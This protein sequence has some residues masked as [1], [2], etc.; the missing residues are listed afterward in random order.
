MSRNMSQLQRALKPKAR[1]AAPSAVSRV[2]ISRNGFMLSRSVGGRHVDKG[3]Q[4]VVQVALGPRHVLPT[5]TSFF[6]LTS[7]SRRRAARV[8]PTV[9]GGQRTLDVCGDRKVERP[10]SKRSH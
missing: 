6:Q 9:M 8:L 10:D 3:L 7:S 4:L 5:L 2:A 1:A